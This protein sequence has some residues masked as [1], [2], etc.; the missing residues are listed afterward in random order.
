MNKFFLIAG[1]TASGKSHLALTLAQQLDGVIINAD[2]LQVYSGLEVITARPK[3]EDL[4]KAQHFLYGVVDPS[5]AYSTGEWL[6]AVKQLIPNFHQQPV[7]FVGGTG[8]YFRALLGG[9]AEVPPID[10]AVRFKWRR[11]LEQK[12]RAA[13]YEIL[14][15][16][17]PVTASKI[18]PN[19][20]QRIARALEVFDMTGNPLS[21]WQ[22]QRSTP[23]FNEDQVTRLIISPDRE[24]LYNA[25]DKRFD[26][27]VNNGALQE[28]ND[29]LQRGLDPSLPAMKAIG[30]DE[31]RRYL[32]REISLDD[33][34]AFAKM[35]TRQYAK[36]QMTWFRNQFVDDW[37]VITTPKDLYDFINL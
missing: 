16:L 6:R 11:E 24:A 9:V 35:H 13:L 32:K 4:A 14:L 29:F 26:A 2:S 19:D 3:R 33:A 12:G 27:M 10:D 28:V 17:D 1:P 30:I 37:R 7:I 36:R 18:T 25:I 8:L 20:G 22:A 34:V 23:I 5:I 21:Y 31:F 15:K